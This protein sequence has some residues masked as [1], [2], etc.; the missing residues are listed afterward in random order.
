MHNFYFGGLKIMKVMIDIGHGGSD[1]GASGNELIE[2]DINLK[3]GI[4]LYN[5]LSQYDVEVRTTR[6]SDVTLSNDV[7]VELVNSYNPDLCVSVHHNAA[8]AAEA[9]GAEVIH[10]H[11]DEYDDKLANEILANMATIGMPKRRIF[12]KLNSRGDDW[13]YMIRRIWDTNTHAIIVEG[14]FVTNA[15]DAA[16]L[17]SD[18]F[19]KLESVAIGSAI[20]EYLGLKLK[21]NNWWNEAMQRIVSEGLIE[22]EHNGNDFVT[23]GEF[24]TVMSRL[25]DKL[26]L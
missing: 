25:L 10:A 12:T 17:K 18:D 3:V 11:Y 1:N 14:G 21:S 22:N 2:K 9:R 7:R 16:L 24:A 5:Y 15:E 8:S 23:W 6:N 4:M 13:Y 19:L 20:V 26:K